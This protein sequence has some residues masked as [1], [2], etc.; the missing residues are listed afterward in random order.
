MKLQKTIKIKIGKLSK[1]KQNI[2]EVLLRK[3]TKAINFCLQKAKKGNIITHNLVY[4]DLRKLNLPATVIH[5]CR[6]KSVEIIKSFYKRKGKKTFPKLKNSRVR[7]DNQVVKLRKTDNKLYKYFVSLL[8]KA[9]VKGNS[10]N[11]IELPLILNSQYQTEILKN[12]GNEYKLGSTELVNKDRDYF[13][14]ISYSKDIEIP[15]PDETFNPIGIDVGIRNL[16]VVSVARQQPK[17]FSGKRIKWKRNFFFEQRRKLLMNFALQEVKR[18]RG[19]E[20]KYLDAVN[21]NI[22]KQIVEM[23]KKTEKPAIVMEDLTGITKFK[24]WTKKGNRNLSNWAFRRLQNTI[25]QKALWEGIPVEYIEPKDTTRTCSKCGTI[26]KRK[27]DNYKCRKCGYEIHSDLNATFNIRQFW[28]DK[29]QPEQ[30][31]INIASNDAISEPQAKKSGSLLCTSIKK[32]NGQ[33]V[34]NFK[35]KEVSIPPITKVMGILEKVL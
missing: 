2:L 30:A 9:G 24:I 15:K 25:Q 19:R 31:T 7:Y 32:N 20:T 26:N 22:A 10:N 28:L 5:G 27:R 34:R 29:F 11:R 4:K 18:Q 17:F 21:Y 6:A 16:A 14:H 13:I 1:N 3:N 35:R 33:S 23:A 12:I 8:Y